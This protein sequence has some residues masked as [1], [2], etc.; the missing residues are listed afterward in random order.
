VEPTYTQDPDLQS[1]ES[2]HASPFI[3]SLHALVPRLVLRRQMP[4]AHSTSMLHVVP[5]LLSPMQRIVLVLGSLAH[6]P[7]MQSPLSVQLSP[8]LPRLQLPL[9]EPELMTQ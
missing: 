5:V 8:G 4:L 7:D 6:S 2:W 1:V 3:P 9:V